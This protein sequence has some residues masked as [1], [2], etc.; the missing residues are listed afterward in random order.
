MEYRGFVWFLPGT[1]WQLSCIDE[2]EG[3]SLDSLRVKVVV[4]G[5]P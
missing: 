3:A 2:D 1:I 5:F 4:G